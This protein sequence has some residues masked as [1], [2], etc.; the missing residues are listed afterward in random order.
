MTAAPSF[1]P[2]DV[3]RRYALAIALLIGVRFVAAAFLPLFFGDEPYYW[4]WS[5][6]LAWGYFDHPPAIAWIIRAGTAI[7]GDTE[8]GVRFFG[9]LLSIPATLCVWR[10]GTLLLGG[11]EH[12]ARA[13]L[14]FNLTLLVHALT[15]MALP[16]APL[17]PCAAAFIWAVA[18]AQTSKDGRWWL[19]AALFA[20]LGLLAKYA[21]LFLGAGVFGWLVLT[22]D[23][24]RWLATPW[25]WLGGAIA[26]LVFLPN[27]IWNAL[28][29][30][31]SLGFQ[32][33][34]LG[35]TGRGRWYYLPQLI[36]EQLAVAS[37]FILILA[38]IGV[39]QATR[40]RDQGRQL[41]AAFIWPLI[42]F[43]CTYVFV[44]R[45]HRN[46]AA[47]MYPALALA[48]ADAFRNRA[49]PPF[50]RRAAVPTAVALLV[51][52]YA[53]A[54][55]HPVS[56]APYDQLDH[57]LAS[58]MRRVAAPVAQAVAATKA[59]AILTTDFPITSWLNFYLRPQVP[60][61]IVAD[62]FRFITA[63]RAT[64]QDLQGTL[65]HVALK[66]DMLYVLKERFSQVERLK[67]LPPTPWLIYRVSG[68]KGEP[69]G[70]IP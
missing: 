63:P 70:R 68:F 18:E 40:S 43:C 24:R 64:A 55:F 41:I 60:I 38:M 44:D 51:I 3:T 5:R 48:A 56:L 7:F 28:N 4:M 52:V 9:L 35:Y 33:G 21:M 34:R 19:L 50:I 61:I 8:F 47:V 66:E 59:R 30:W 23:G 27:V 29:D 6:H 36:A 53:Q 69:Y 54:L 14:F 12:G 62:D 65:I 17:L 2:A 11:S 42:I 10:T 22:A 16:D 58:D 39:W 25:P 49:G 31:P 1:H 67:D 45:I 37:P 26:A 20:G 57:R 46:W 13:A 32:F 15:F